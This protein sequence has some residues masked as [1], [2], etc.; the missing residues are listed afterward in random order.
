MADLSRAADGYEAYF[1]EKLWALVPAIYRSLDGSDEQKGVVRGLIETIASQAAILRRDQDRL[2]DDSFI[3]LCDDW[4]VPYIGDLVGTRMISALDK[5]GRRIDVAKTI[6]YRR[7][8]GTP[9][10]LEELIADITPWDGTVVEA[11]RRR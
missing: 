1:T 6:Y 4:A 11:F 8:K 5:R 2:W 7:R 10:V 9:R 3:D